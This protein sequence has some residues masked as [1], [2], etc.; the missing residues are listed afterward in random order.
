MSCLLVRSMLCT[1]SL[2]GLLRVLTRHRMCSTLCM[3]SLLGLR[4]LMS[5]H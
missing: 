5:S 3:L 2:L 1:L 4:K